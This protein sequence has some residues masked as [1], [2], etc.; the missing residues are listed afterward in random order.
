MIR[1]SLRHFSYTILLS[2]GVLPWV[3]VS[4]LSA[5]TVADNAFNKTIQPFLRVYCQRCHNEVKPES[6]VRVDGL[7]S[8]FPDNQLFLWKDV[9]KQLV[10]ENM[11]PE[12]EVQP[13]TEQRAALIH[14]IREEMRSAQARNNEKHGSVR[15]LTVSQYRR[16]LHDLLGLDDNIAQILPPDGISKD[17]FAN[18]GQL[19]GLTP[20]QLEYYFEVADKA[21]DL[22]IV[23]ERSKPVVQNLRMALGQNINANPLSE[24]LILGANN[25]LLKNQDFVVTELTPDKPFGFEPSKMR[26]AYDFVEG[27]AGN[28]TVR[29][30]RKYDNIYH[31]VFACMRGTEGYPKGE[32]YQIRSN[33]LL[34]RPAIPSSEIWEQSSTYG[35]RANFKIS[36]RELPDH[37]NFRVKVKAAKCEDALLLN[38]D[39]NT[40]DD[41]PNSVLAS[42]DPVDSTGNKEI[43]LHAAGIYQVDLHYQSPEISATSQDS[44]ADKGKPKVVDRESWTVTINGDRFE[45]KV[46]TGWNANQTSTTLPSPTSVAFL[47]RRL[48]KG[49]LNWNVTTGNTIKLER[50]VFTQVDENSPEGKEFCAFEK[51]SPWLGVHMGL[52]RD[53]GSTLEQVG[54]PQRVS[55]YEWND[56]VFEGAIANYPSPYVEKDNVNYLAGIREIGVRH[57]YTDGRDVPRLLIQSIEFEGPYYSSWPPRQHRNIFIDSVNKEDPSTYANEIL[58]SFMTKAY[59]R[60]VAQDEF[61]RIAKVWKESYSL[62]KDFQGSIKD[63][64]LVVLTSPQF[65]FLVETSRS[66]EHEDLTPF[67]LASKLSYF[68]WNAPPDQQLLEK[69]LSNQLREDFDNQLDRIFDDDKMFAFASEFAA[70]WLGLDKFENVD[71]DERIFPR[72]TLHTRRQLRKEPVQFFHYLIQKNLALKNIINSKWIMANDSVAAY[73][74][75]GDRIESGFDFIPLEHGRDHLGGV[76]SQSSILAGLSN[77]RESNPVKRGA[78]F[79]RRIIAEPPDDPPPN[80]P[81]LPDDDLHNRSLRERLEMHRNQKVCAKCHAGIDPW[82]IAFEAFDASGTIKLHAA[83]TSTKLPD[84]TQIGDFQEF[85]EYLTQ[86]RMERIAFSFLKH[87]ATYAIGRSL[88]YNES[89]FLENAA[90]TWPDQEYRV[91]DLIRFIVKSDLF[92]KK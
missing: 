68:L 25:H 10:E 72:L 4:G 30:W 38:D 50:V 56:Y 49:E 24:N 58:R 1:F 59:R 69:A 83:D 17:G 82:G 43:H 86:K 39:A 19:M 63:A 62:K 51:R 55:G 77:G 61:E 18:N 29:G 76:L 34:L 73:Y 40:M 20:L 5:Q 81:E 52:R 92:L 57:E 42:S 67:E 41:N 8:Y 26:T 65:L 78:W 87:I 35:P 27:Y 66:P 3:N 15:R 36:L 53:C 9:L 79:A 23:D 88:S 22:C 32:A 6:G 64:L 33:G 45:R 60:P 11:P 75:L 14:S 80:V 70:Q 48:P 16:T 7:E 90:E 85:R 54:G 71:I 21:I 44:N 47:R 28:D 74:G 2:F 12:G 91:R 84:G 46:K 31:S 89:A 37:G 13:T